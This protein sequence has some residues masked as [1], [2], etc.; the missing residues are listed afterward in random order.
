MVVARRT[1]G[2]ANASSTVSAVEK[3]LSRV[4]FSRVVAAMNALVA[5][6]SSSTASSRD[7]SP[8]SRR[9]TQREMVPMC[10]G[11]PGV[12][13]VLAAANSIGASSLVAIESQNLPFVSGLASS[14]ACTIHRAVASASA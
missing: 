12:V 7:T 2:L 11:C 4:R 8:V 14:A 6:S 9:S 10:A 3:A 5:S 1:A 13:L